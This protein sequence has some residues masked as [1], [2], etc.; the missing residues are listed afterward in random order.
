M[1]FFYRDAVILSKVMTAIVFNSVPLEAI[2]ETGG[3]DNSK[4]RAK[5]LIREM[6]KYGVHNVFSPEELVDMK[7]IHHVT[8]CIDELHHLAENDK[9]ALLS[10]LI[11]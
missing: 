6:M 2:D 1:S 10:S 4:S 5:T 9:G 3:M 7:N 11:G 8:K